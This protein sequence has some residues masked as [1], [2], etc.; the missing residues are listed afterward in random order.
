MDKGRVLNAVLGEMEEDIR[1]QLAA[2]ESAANGATHV[3]ARAET[4]W[5][6]CGLEQSYLARGHAMQFEQLARQ[7]SELRSFV[8]PDFRDMPI[9]IGALVEVKTLGERMMFFLL[10]F[11]GGVEIHFED[12]EI[13]VITPESPVGAAL[14][15][16]RQGDAY[17]FRRGTEGTILGVE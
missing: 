1:R 4:K 3:E 6:T 12:R 15:N 9:G 13:T 8:P 10:K 16:K 5:D 2:Q 7:I 17:S 11:G 14:M